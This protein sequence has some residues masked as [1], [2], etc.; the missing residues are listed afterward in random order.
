MTGNTLTTNPITGTNAYA[1]GA[2]GTPQQGFWGNTVGIAGTTPFGF[3]TQ[4][5]QPQVA[6]PINALN[7]INTLNPINALNPINTLN[8]FTSQM[9]QQPGFVTQT[10]PWQTGFTTPQYGLQGTVQAILQTTPQHVLNT[11][12]QTTPPQVVNTILQ[13]T[14]PQVLP[15]ILNALAC[16]QVC[17]QVLQQNP[18]TIQAIAQQGINQPLFG[19]GTTSQGQYGFGG[20]I[21]GQGF[22]T[23]PFV[24]SYQGQTVPQ[25]FLQGQTVPQQFLQGQNCAGCAPG[26][27]QWVPNSVGFQ[28][29][30]GQVV[31]QQPWF[32]TTYGTW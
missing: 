16:Q 10:T 24:N 28:G 8:P 21:G 14:P 19:Y 4:A 9:V 23:V 15:Y 31:P 6:N 2:Y 18:Q 7:P 20:T 13:T 25:Q 1:N 3:G 11:I 27:Q 12:L 30:F 17:Q 22:N 32:N 26:M 29:S 5:F